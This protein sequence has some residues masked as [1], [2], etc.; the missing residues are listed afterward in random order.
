MKQFI[1]LATAMLLAVGAQAATGHR[2]LKASTSPAVSKVASAKKAD[3]HRHA[4]K[5][6]ASRQHGARKTAAAHSAHKTGRKQS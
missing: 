2:G 5:K 1:V 6:A 3:S 4:G